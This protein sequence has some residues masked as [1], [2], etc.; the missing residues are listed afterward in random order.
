LS[1][2]DWAPLYKL[3]SA[4]AAIDKLN[5]VATKIMDLAIPYILGFLANL[6]FMLRRSIIFTDF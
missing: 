5:A 3:T 4:D 1:N 2:Y 6:N